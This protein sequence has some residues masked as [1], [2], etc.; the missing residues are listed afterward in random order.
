MFWEGGE[1]LDQSVRRLLRFNI[2]GKIIHF[3]LLRSF[4]L[5]K[6]KVKWKFYLKPPFAFWSFSKRFPSVQFKNL[7]VKKNDFSGGRFKKETVIDGHSHLLLIRD[8]GHSQIDV[9]VNFKRE[10]RNLIFLF[11]LYIH[12]LFIRH[13]YLFSW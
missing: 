12:S 6:M 8:E 3:L 2:F 13:L 7:K 10:K 9:Q 5:I 4:N 11:K 1:K